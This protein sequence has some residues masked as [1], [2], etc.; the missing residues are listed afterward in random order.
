MES[1]CV[2]EAEEGTPESNKKGEGSCSKSDANG[3]K[4]SI[5]GNT[6]SSY[7]LLQIVFLESL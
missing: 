4:K 7:G 3:K 1:E 2:C 6:D 5:K